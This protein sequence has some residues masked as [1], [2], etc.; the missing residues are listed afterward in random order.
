[1]DEYSTWE[2][3]SPLYEGVHLR[4][5][6]EV[7][8][9]YKGELIGVLTADEVGE[10][11]RRFTE[12]E[13][14]LL[15]L[16][17]SQAAGAI[18]SARLREQTVQRL[19]ELEVLYQSGLAL[20]QLGN[21]RA[22]A[23]KIIDLLDQKMDWHHTAIQ[24]YHPES[25]TLE[26][27]AFSHPGL[28]T[29]VQRSAAKQRYETP[30]TRAGEGLSG[31]VVRHGETVRSGDLE[32][33]PRYIETFPALRSGLYVPIKFAERVIGMISIEREQADAFGE[34]D[35]QL[36]LT[37][38]TQAAIAINNAQLFDDL[39]RSHFDLASAYDAT[40]EGWSRAMDM[41]DKETEGHTQRVT[42]LTMKMAGALKIDESLLPHIRRGALLHDI[43]KLGVPDSILLKAD[44]LT[45]QEWTIMRQHPNY[46]HE[47]LVSIA[48]LRPALDIP[49]GHHEKWDG[50]GYPQGLSGEQIPLAARIFALADV[51]DALTNDRTYRPA[52]PK[53]K[54]LEYIREQSGKHF[55]PHAVETFL[56][57]V[58]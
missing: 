28:D 46:A 37:L 30:V 32:N 3:R 53:E 2:G 39:Q 35:Q 7:P 23:Q 58:T 29:E 4:A 47:M 16:F 27:L 44:Q 43:G 20:S 31:W 48:Y 24:L 22:I 5:V 38:A 36:A 51:W 6:L 54:A 26:L 34:S 41:R 19:S 55:D 52:W 11:A 57:L 10:S 18:H 45:S 49:Y 8:M 56:R 9:L 25:E 42:N 21:P 12:A 1:V 50:T 17:A 14:H 15:S 33:D 40:I 13:E